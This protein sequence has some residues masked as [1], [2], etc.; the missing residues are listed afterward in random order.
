M[1]SRRQNDMFIRHDHRP[2]TLG[3]ED[4]TCSQPVS[5]DLHFGA[6]PNSDR[7]ESIPNKHIFSLREVIQWALH[8]TLIAGF[9]RVT[10]GYVYQELFG[11]ETR[12]R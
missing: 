5:C 10:L 12:S 4:G 2:E 9:V 8:G 3:N 7:V 6:L 11:M 1:T